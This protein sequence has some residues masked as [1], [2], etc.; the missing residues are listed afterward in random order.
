MDRILDQSKALGG[1]KNVGSMEEAHAVM[2]KL[3]MS[4]EQTSKMP[5]A[6]AEFMGSKG[7]PGV[8]DLLKNIWK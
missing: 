4:A 2:S 1:F 6:L 8:A 5:E 3:G 7:G